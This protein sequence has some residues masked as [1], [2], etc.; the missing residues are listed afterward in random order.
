MDVARG[1][2]KPWRVKRTR[3]MSPRTLVTHKKTERPTWAAP[4]V[5]CFFV[6][7]SNCPYAAAASSMGV[8][9]AGSLRSFSPAEFA[10][11]TN[12]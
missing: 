1:A 7:P 12:T 4:P 9:S 6:V 11:E 5:V 3:G 2:S 8:T 10:V